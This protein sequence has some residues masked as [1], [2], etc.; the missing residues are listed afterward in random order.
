MGTDAV[1]YDSDLFCLRSY[2]P[3]GIG[4]SCPAASK[5]ISI[6]IE[7]TKLHFDPAI[8]ILTGTHK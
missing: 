8:S 4:S 1:L 6:Q 5:H 3:Q 2:W 7:L